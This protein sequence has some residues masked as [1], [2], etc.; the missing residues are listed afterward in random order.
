M[1]SPDIVENY[2][3]SVFQ[4]GPMNDRVYL[5]KV[6]ADDCTAV[7]DHVEE[8]AA[9]RGYSK[10]FAKIPQRLRDDLLGRGYVLEASVPGFFA[11]RETGDFVCKYL[12]PERAIDTRAQEERKVLD[13]AMGKKNS[14][15]RPLPAGFRIDRCGERHIEKMAAI[16][17]KVFKSYPFP[18]DSPEYLLETMRTHVAYFGCWVG[19]DL[20]ALSSAEMDHDA[21][22]AEMTD[23][24]TLDE[25]R[26]LGLATSLLAEMEKTMPAEGIA[27]AYTIARSCSIG[28][29]ATFAR[30]NYE[31]G[32]KL[33]NNTNIAG[34]F[35][36]M[37]V[38]YK[39]L[40]SQ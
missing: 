21:C 7:L 33:V 23:F 37:N 3:D 9:R 5:M 36:S 30:T 32:G 24:A 8:L 2:K 10:I 14:P 29:N 39:L 35:E 20:V 13:I 27:C 19:S 11:G 31:F 38:W 16:Y 25:H 17:A 4:H 34:R 22:N 40:G 1:T 15:A 28:M 12:D 18:I 6:C 26:G